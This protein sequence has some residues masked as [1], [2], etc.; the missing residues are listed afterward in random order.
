M[1]IK[2]FYW[3]GEIIDKLQWKHSVTQDEIKETFLSKPRFRFVEKGK[4]AGED[5]YA[6]L[7]RTKSGRYLITFFIYKSDYHALI[8]S[9]RDMKK[10]ERKL[11]G[12]K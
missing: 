4:R 3:L 2:G 8:L 12:K 5:V 1:K 6:A 11:Y 7:G 9:S 10:G